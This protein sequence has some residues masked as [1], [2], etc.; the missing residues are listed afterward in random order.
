M[1]KFAAE[2]TVGD[3]DCVYSGWETDRPGG[4]SDA[5]V[6][7]LRRLSPFLAMAMKCASLARIAQALVE[8]Y[9]G[10]EAGRQVLSGRIERGSPT[11]SRPCSGSAICAA[12]PA[13]PTTPSRPRSSRC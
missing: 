11:G 12:S 1:N 7:A 6:L 13:S 9:L 4:F 10:R 2:G 8:T 5:E 3:M